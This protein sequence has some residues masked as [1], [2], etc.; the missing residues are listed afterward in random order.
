M[1]NRI[2]RGEVLGFRAGARLR[3]ERNKDEPELLEAVRH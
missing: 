2:S 3:E 1:H